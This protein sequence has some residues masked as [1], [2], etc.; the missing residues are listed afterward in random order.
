MLT[1]VWKWTP[2]DVVQALK[3]APQDA[4]IMVQSPVDQGNGNRTAEV[5]GPGGPTS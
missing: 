4:E 3:S 2:R 5:S 1:S